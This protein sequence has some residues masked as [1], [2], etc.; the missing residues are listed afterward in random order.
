ME[1][2][3]GSYYSEK[4]YYANYNSVSDG[5]DFS[6]PYVYAGYSIKLP[7]GQDLA[8]GDYTF[9]ITPAEGAVMTQTV[10]FPETLEVP[11]VDSTTMTYSW[12]EGALTL[13]WT[14]PSG[15]FDDFRVVI[16]GKDDKELLYVQAPIPS[17]RS[18]SRP[19]GLID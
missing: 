13:S 3:V 4:Y 14:A 11:V 12:A 2:I 10:A 8:A 17:H 5:F 7:A 9:E 19:I 16:I 6:G 18:P 1:A 15:T